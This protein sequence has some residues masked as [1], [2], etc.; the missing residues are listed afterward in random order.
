MCYILSG[1]VYHL[2]HKAKQED[3]GTAQRVESSGTG[4]FAARKPASNEELRD[5][6]VD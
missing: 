5:E 6:G 3:D 4:D 1:P 2:H